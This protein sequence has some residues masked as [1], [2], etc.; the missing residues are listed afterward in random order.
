MLL[1]S[2]YD[3]LTK[4]AMNYTWH[5]VTGTFQ[6]SEN[7][8]K[9][10]FP[11]DANLFYLK[12]L[13]IKGFVKYSTRTQ[14]VVD[15]VGWI[16]EFTSLVEKEVK[17][18]GYE[19]RFEYNLQENVIKVKSKDTEIIEFN[20]NFC[21]EILN[22]N[23]TISFV[24]VPTFD[25]YVFWLDILNDPRMFDMFLAFIN[26]QISSFNF[27]R[28]FSFT[29]FEN[30]D[31]SFLSEIYINSI[32]DYFKQASFTK[33]KVINEQWQWLMKLYL[34]ED[35]DAYIVEKDNIYLIICKL[36]GRLEFV[37]F[38]DEGNIDYSQTI[39]DE[40]DKLESK[41]REKV[42]S[43]RRIKLHVNN[44]VTDNA[45]TTTQI[46]GVLITPVNLLILFGISPLGLTWMKDV[47]NSIYSYIFMGVLLVL[48]IM[49]YIFW[50]VIPNIKL[51][52]FNWRLKY[53]H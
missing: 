49:G 35:L 45:K 1:G 19:Y 2:E 53:D 20:V 44:K 18:K 14:L 15:T 51:L 40:L 8:Y 46:A 52:R 21:D 9:L 7:D 22:Y 12:K 23:N 13:V 42:T 11:D 30:L 47:I 17:R 33:S 4:I 34:R 41:L 25:S 31:A 27:Q 38:D 50:L 36:D 5:S 32:P 3:T 29:F 24:Y 6:F 10:K 16:T 37:S 43:Y 26:K 28:R 39:I 48:I